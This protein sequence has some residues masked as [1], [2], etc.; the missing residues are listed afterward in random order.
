MLPS[1]YTQLSRAIATVFL[2]VIEDAELAGCYALEGALG[3]D[4]EVAARQEAYFGGTE[5]GRMAYLDGHA[6]GRGEA[7]RRAHGVAEGIDCQ[8]MG[9]CDAEVVAVG[10]D[11][12]VAVHHPQDVAL[13]VLL[14]DVP[15]A[16]AEAEAFA[17]PDGVEP[18][19]AMHAQHATRL[20]VDDLSG[21]LAEV[22]ADV[23]V[24]VNLAEEA[25]ALAVLAVSGQQMLALGDGPH[26]GLGQ[27]ADG[28]AGFL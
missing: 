3:V 22:L 11:G 1:I 14:D 15:G 10:L 23:V 9:R 13:H 5:V 12:I 20:A 24:V 18:E 4:V 28:E 21:L 6:E 27:M 8:P 19:A 16:A 2:C 25:D 17:L 7:I 26:F